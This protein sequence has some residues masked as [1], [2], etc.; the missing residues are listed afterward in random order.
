MAIQNNEPW[1]S[2]AEICEYLSI[3]NDTVYRLIKSKKFPAQKI[4]NRWKAQKS[5]IDLWITSNNSTPVQKR[6]K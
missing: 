6:I 5:Q 2:L 1:L 3:S 4:G